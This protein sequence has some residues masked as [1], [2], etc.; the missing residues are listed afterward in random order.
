MPPQG[1]PMAGPPGYTASAPQAKTMIAQPSPF[2]AGGPLAGHGV[3]P[4][5]MPPGAMPSGSAPPVAAP[6]AY[7]PLGASQK[8]I[9]AGMAPPLV[10]G[11]LVPGQMPPGAIGQ[12]PVPQ[13]TPGS[14][15]PP[16]PA[17]AAGPNK[18]V[19]LQPS[20]GIVS[21]ARS[22]QA[23]QAATSRIVEGASTLYWIVCLCMGIAVGVLAYVVYLQV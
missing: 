16:Q 22:G 9:V 19:L 20:E 2:Q 8:T 1:A 12:M 23:V 7:Q 14:G 13:A 18:T 15:F 3:P 21:V 17:P 11:P 10:G 6:S 4:G 5:G